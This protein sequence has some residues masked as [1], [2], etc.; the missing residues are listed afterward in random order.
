MVPHADPALYSPDD[1]IKSRQGFA[2]VESG[3]TVLLIPWLMPYPR[4]RDQ[5]RREATQETPEQ[6]E[7]KPASS[8]CRYEGGI[9]VVPGSR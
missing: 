6:G 4:Q 9:K 5:R 1:R 3:D 7:V 8:V 2:L